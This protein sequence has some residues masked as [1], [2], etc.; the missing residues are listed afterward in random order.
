MANSN[1]DRRPERQQQAHEAASP[2]TRPRYVSLI[3]GAITALSIFL[4]GAFAGIQTFTQPIPMLMAVGF[5]V[6]VHYLFAT[7]TNRAHHGA[8]R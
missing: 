5:S 1:Q 6:S 3:G 8:D 2:L 4:F 7:F